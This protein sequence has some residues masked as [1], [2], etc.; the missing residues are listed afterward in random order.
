MKFLLLTF[1]LIAL[2]ACTIQAQ[3]RR[4]EPV[5]D[6]R[7]V[8]AKKR[9]PTTAH[10]PSML[11]EVAAEKIF[12]DSL[13]FESGKTE[14]KEYGMNRLNHFIIQIDEDIQVF[15]KQYP[16]ELLL[17]KIRIMQDTKLIATNRVNTIYNYLIER[18]V[19]AGN[20]QIYK[21][22]VKENRENNQVA[23]AVSLG[24]DAE[25]QR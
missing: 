24:T 25:S 15:R 3:M 22:I 18:L 2:F 16:T 19:Q 7:I 4:T 20:I 14:L 17:L 5:L 9:V 6:M 1:V 10:H 12:S 8:R 23:S 13:A 11:Q 21:E